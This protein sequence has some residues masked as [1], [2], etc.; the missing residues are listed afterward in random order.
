M[1]TSID[2]HFVEQ[3]EAEVHLAYQRFGAMLRNTVRRK[4]NVLGKQTNFRKTG[5]GTA[6]TKSRHG[7]VPLADLAHTTVPCVLG[8]YYLGEFL[9]E[10]DELKT[11]IDE[12]EV[13]TV[14]LAAAM[15]RKADE[16]IRDDG[17][18]Q[19]TNQT[20]TTGGVT[21]AKIEIIYEAFG[22]KEVPSD[23]QRYL[24]VSAQGF[25]D[26]MT[27]Q[28]FSQAEFIGS[29]NLPWRNPIG[30]KRFMSF[31][32]FEY[33]GWNKAAAIRTSMAWHRTAIGH[34]SGKEIGLDIT[35]QGKEQAHLAVTSMSQGS[36]TIDVDGLFEL[37]HTEV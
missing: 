30:A 14:S 15:G 33:S 19:A 26:L 36:C 17:L 6:G 5:K 32:V 20:S 23:G 13:A 2:Q 18:T 22:N 16:L 35:W 29:E 31:I 28:E 9:D 27:L 21:K 3:F 12:R 25:T 8:D 10:L 1:S 37:R 4:D 24:S 34:A 7:Q 11:N